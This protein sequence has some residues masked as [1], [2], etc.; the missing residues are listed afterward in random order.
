MASVATVVVMVTAV[1]I[2]IVWWVFDD[3]EAVR[4]EAV[5]PYRQVL[6]F[7]KA[8]VWLTVLHRIQEWCRWVFRCA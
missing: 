4:A 3:W 8:E 6:I 1:V 5:V 2:V 7:A